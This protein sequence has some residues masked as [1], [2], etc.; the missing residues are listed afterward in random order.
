MY[1]LIYNHRIID[2]CAAKNGRAYLVQTMLFPHEEIE[3]EYVKW[4]VERLVLIPH[5]RQ[6]KVTRQAG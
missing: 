2:Y 6:L 5:H 1:Y 3:A 4:L